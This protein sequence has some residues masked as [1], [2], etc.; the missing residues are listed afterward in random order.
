MESEKYPYA[1]PST[2][3][4]RS[5]FEKPTVTK[6]TAEQAKLKL[7]GAATIGDQ[8]AIDLLKLVFSEFPKEHDT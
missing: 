2:E 3:K 8:G 1:K 7:L 5:P 4:T 6:L